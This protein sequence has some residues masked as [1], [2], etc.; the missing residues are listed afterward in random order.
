MYILTNVEKY[1]NLKYDEFSPKFSKIR[2][3]AKL[4]D[5]KCVETYVL[6]LENR[7]KSNK[8]RKRDFK[9]LLRN[10]DYFEKGKVLTVKYEH[11]ISI[12]LFI[13]LS[14][15]T[16]VKHSYFHSV[17]SEMV[18]KFSSFELILQKFEHDFQQKLHIRRKKK[19]KEVFQKD[20]GF[21]SLECAVYD[22]DV[23]EIAATSTSSPQTMSI[24]AT[25]T[26][27]PQME[28][29]SIE[30]ANFL[31]AVFQGKDFY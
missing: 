3:T 25:S 20:A 1:A 17:V 12:P 28:P 14:I 10:L 15:L 29:I 26:S 9:H 24:A 8:M 18:P 7:K 31:E 21:G 22:N 16:H 4:I 13:L 11:R 2:K 6:D 5:Q 30:D 27:S 23:D 19:S